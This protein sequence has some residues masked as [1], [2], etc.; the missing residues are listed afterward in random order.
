[1]NFLDILNHKHTITVLMLKSSFLIAFGVLSFS[2]LVIP[3][4]ESP[5]ALLATPLPPNTGTTIATTTPPVVAAKEVSAPTMPE[6]LMVP[7]IALNDAITKVGVN[8]K[9]EMDV[10]AGN[11][12]NVGWYADGTVPGTLGSAVID[13]HVF[14]AFSKLQNIKVGSDIYIET[15]SGQ[16]LHFV[17]QEMKTYALADV[18][19]D[20][21][22]N[23]ADAERLN[24]ITCAGK[25][26]A[27]RSTYDHRLVVYA[28]LVP[29]AS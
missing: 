3:Q 16:K 21:L 4:L 23:R 1:M 27:D 20:L 11:T 6:R 7:S 18:P 22:F 8:A 9:G 26:T 19:A 24:L 28:T 15:D 10:P 14:A 5:A 17:V 2:P 12:K 13:A 29:D 25:L